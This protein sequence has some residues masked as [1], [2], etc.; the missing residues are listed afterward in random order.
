[1]TWKDEASA[2]LTTI[3]CQTGSRWGDDHS[4]ANNWLFSWLDRGIADEVVTAELTPK[5][6]HECLTTFVNTPNSFP[7][8]IKDMFGKLKD[9]AERQRKAE[10]YKVTSLS[11]LKSSSSNGDGEELMENEVLDRIASQPP[12]Q[13]KMFDE[14][15][16]QENITSDNSDNGFEP[17]WITTFRE[18]LQKIADEQSSDLQNIA[19]RKKIDPQDWITTFME[20]LQNIPDWGSRDSQKMRLAMAIWAFD[21]ALAHNEEEHLILRQSEEDFDAREKL[22]YS[23]RKIVLETLLLFGFNSDSKPGDELIALER[24]T[25]RRFESAFNKASGIKKPKSE[26][27]KEQKTESNEEKGQE[28]TG[29]EKKEQKTESNEKKAFLWTRLARLII[30]MGDYL[31]NIHSSHPGKWLPRFNFGGKAWEASELLTPAE[32]TL[33]KAIELERGGVSGASYEVFLTQLKDEAIWHLRQKKRYLLGKIFNYVA[34]LEEARPRLLGEP[35]QNREMVYRKSAERLKQLEISSHPWPSQ[36]LLVDLAKH[37]SQVAV[38]TE[39]VLEDLVQ[40]DEYRPYSGIPE[41]LVRK[42]DNVRPLWDTIH[43][44][45]ETIEELWCYCDWRSVAAVLTP[46][47]ERGFTDQHQLFATML[48]MKEIAERAQSVEKDREEQLNAIAELLRL[49]ILQPGMMRRAVMLF[50]L[51]LIPECKDSLLQKILRDLVAMTERDPDPVVSVLGA[52]AWHRFDE[53][54]PC[55]VLSQVFLEEEERKLVQAVWQGSDS[56]TREYL[57]QGLVHLLDSSR[58]EQRLSAIFTLAHLSERFKAEVDSAA[59]KNFEA[60]WQHVAKGILSRLTDKDPFIAWGVVIALVP[61]VMSFEPNLWTIDLVAYLRGHKETACMMICEI[62][63]E[64][65]EDKFRAKVMA[66]MGITSPFTFLTLQSATG[67]LLSE[68]GHSKKRRAAVLE[69]LGEL[70]ETGEITA[71]HVAGWVRHRLSRIE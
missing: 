21:I 26:K 19:D 13:E 10:G 65:L 5:F 45:V 33:R 44:L 28:Q 31:N 8:M 2:V 59:K 70:E 17:N 12:E 52:L 63:E 27:K 14:N 61:V 15:P 36:G 47:I 71:I 6:S 4:T 46:A 54:S 16:E 32:Q 29:S 11:D 24:A 9:K 50:I 53:V 42:T 40:I 39:A 23:I 7:Q 41:E 60:Y 34:V 56:F 3:L 37:T 68:V 22:R 58:L 35:I 55:D 38:V 64:A 62:L 20:T 69:L 25:F 30:C 43:L 51:P 18:I 67:V 1:M 48:A 57:A 66:L 49:G